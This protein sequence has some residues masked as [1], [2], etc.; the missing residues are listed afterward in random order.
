[1]VECPWCVAPYITFVD[2]V[3][4]WSTDLHWTWWFGNVWAAVSWIAAYM[5]LRDIPPEQ[6]E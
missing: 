3:W 4:A 5:C 1:L 6:R 2:L